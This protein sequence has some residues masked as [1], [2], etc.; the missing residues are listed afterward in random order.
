MEKISNLYEVAAG[1]LL[2]EDRRLTLD[3]LEKFVGF[4]HK[5][6]PHADMVVVTFPD[7]TTKGIE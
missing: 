1:E 2:E 6:I 7:N 3:G 4:V 5:E